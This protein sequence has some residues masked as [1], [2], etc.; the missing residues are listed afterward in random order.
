MITQ[1]SAL[2]VHIGIARP[3]LIE[4]IILEHQ[5]IG[6]IIFLIQI[7]G[8][9]VGVIKLRVPKIVVIVGVISASDDEKVLWVRG[10]DNFTDQA[11]VEV[12]SDFVAVF[13][14]VVDL[15]G[16]GFLGF[17]VFGLRQVKHLQGAVVDFEGDLVH[18]RFGL[19]PYQDDAFVDSNIPKFINSV[20]DII[21]I[22]AR[23]IR[24][25]QE[26]EVATDAIFHNWIWVGIGEHFID[27]DLTELDSTNR[28]E[29]RLIAEGQRL[30][31]IRCAQHFWFYVN[32]H[33]ELLMVKGYWEDFERFLDGFHLLVGL[34]LG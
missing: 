11:G 10:D 26:C 22:V 4:Q 3:Q 8:L 28:K 9:V 2:E 21:K 12:E 32:Y 16:E 1:R 6:H 20:K 5:V 13:K 14:G 24:M 31:R 33:H 17:E 19:F 29:S 27:S 30:Q 7:L 23:I 18:D 25:V 15:G 34:F